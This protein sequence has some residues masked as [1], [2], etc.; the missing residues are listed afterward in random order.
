MT[1]AGGPSTRNNNS[2][3]TSTFWLNFSPILRFIY[4]PYL[5]LQLTTFFDSTL[6]HFHI[7]AFSLQISHITQPPNVSTIFLQQSYNPVHLFHTFGAIFRWL[8][9]HNPCIR[10]Q[11]NPLF[12][13]TP[14][15]TLFCNYLN[16]PTYYSSSTGTPNPIPASWLSYYHIP[17][18]I[19]A[20]I[21]TLDPCLFRR[22]LSAIYHQYH[23]FP[24]FPTT[25]AS[26]IH[27][28]FIHSS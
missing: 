10:W 19:T 7:P 6:L 17:G 21:I 24:P 14:N 22:Q 27:A 2:I 26:N 4:C 3:P 13:L 20:S 25:I 8:T 11:P 28:H 15:P 18:S 23:P 5:R 12:L 16:P 9:T 1:E